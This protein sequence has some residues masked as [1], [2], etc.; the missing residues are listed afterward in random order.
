MDLAEKYPN[1]ASFGFWKRKRLNRAWL[2]HCENKAA[3]TNM[4]FETFNAH[5]CCWPFFSIVS[6]RSCKRRLELSEE[7]SPILERS[8]LS[9]QRVCRISWRVH[10][11]SIFSILTIPSDS[12][13]PDTV[14]TLTTSLGANNFFYL[15]SGRWTRKNHFIFSGTVL[16]QVRSKLWV[17]LLKGNKIPR[18][19]TH[20]PIEFKLAVLF[21]FE[22]WQNLSRK[23]T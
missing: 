5:R 19:P 10:V 22:I 1:A 9:H 17:S 13:R 20:L 11:L 14:A 16:E 23:F 2:G 3:N 6:G 18:P 21:E 4:T 7:F 8:L 12:S 15:I